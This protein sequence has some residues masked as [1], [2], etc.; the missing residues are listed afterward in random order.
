MRTRMMQMMG[1]AAM[2]VTAFLAVP[3]AA[4]APAQAPA[5][6]KVDVTGIWA[7]EVQTEN[8]TGTPQLTF[9]QEGEKLTGHYSSQLLG[10]ADLAGTV[11]GQA[12]EFVVAANVQGNAIELSFV[13]T[14]ENKDAM[15]GKVSLAGMGEG[16]FTGK[17]K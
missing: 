7:F 11:K 17:R 3:A 12:I 10:E 4:P 6:A 5:P 1:V 16:T 14:I 15:K 9:K 2:V 13:G 8:G